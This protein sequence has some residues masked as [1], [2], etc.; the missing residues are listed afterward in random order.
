[1][2][3]RSSRGER[4]VPLSPPQG[5]EEVPIPTFLMFLLQDDLDCGAACPLRPEVARDEAQRGA[6]ASGGWGVQ[7]SLSPAVP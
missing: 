5:L 3:G 6:E 7:A 2:G 4:G 1:M